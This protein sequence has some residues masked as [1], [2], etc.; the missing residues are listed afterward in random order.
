MKR[1]FSDLGLLLLRLSFSAMLLTHGYGK[2]LRLF[3]PDIKF[4]DFLGLGATV[5][6]FLAV[7]GEFIAPILIMI[8]Y[9]T[10]LVTLFPIVTM[11]VAAFIAHADDPFAKKEKALLFL[12]GFIAIA[13][14]G[15]GKY[16]L[17]QRFKK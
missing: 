3:E 13:L 16:A 4:M 17:D 11:A 7:L 1:N 14:C 8:G 10:R 5:S 9:K 12:F 2:F 15:A 6:L